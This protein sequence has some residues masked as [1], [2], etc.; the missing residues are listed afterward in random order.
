MIIDV[1]RTRTDGSKGEVASRERYLLKEV[2]PSRTPLA[3]GALLFG[4]AA[5][6]KSALPGWSRIPP[7]DPAPGQPEEDGAPRLRLIDTGMAAAPDPVGGTDALSGE[8]GQPRRIGSGTFLDGRLPSAE[9]MLV[10]S[11]PLSFPEPLTRPFAQPVDVSG[12]A[13]FLG[14]LA[15]VF[16]FRI[17][18][19]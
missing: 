15:V 18:R 9:F 2:R 5:Y 14:T 7:E 19:G 8:E 10:D 17:L 3:V 1:K 6:L 11:P 13:R 12:F 4:L 16:F